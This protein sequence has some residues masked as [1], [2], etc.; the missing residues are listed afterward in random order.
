[1]SF[2]RVAPSRV[3]GLGV[4]SRVSEWSMELMYCVHDWTR[5]ESTVLTGSLRSRG[6]ERWQGLADVDTER[7]IRN[8]FKTPAKRALED[9][10]SD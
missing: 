7:T 9:V 6:R 10:S 8:E 2:D 4:W 1:M 3:W 5:F